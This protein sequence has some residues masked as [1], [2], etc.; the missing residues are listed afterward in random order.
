MT[1]GSTVIVDGSQIEI[2]GFDKDKVGTQAIRYEYGAAYIERSVTVLKRDVGEITV[3]FSL[4]GDDLHDVNGQVHTLLT[5]ILLTWI[6]DKEY[7]SRRKLHSSRCSYISSG[8]KR[9]NFFQI[10]QV[11][12]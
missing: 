1:D 11:I 8:R 12:I 5:E 6:D 7:T 4:M 10:L 2:T 3:K 9:N